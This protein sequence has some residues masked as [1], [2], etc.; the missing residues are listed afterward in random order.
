MAGSASDVFHF[1][2]AALDRFLLLLVVKSIRVRDTAVI[3]TSAAIGGS[4]TSYY[5]ITEPHMSP[6]NRIVLRLVMS[7]TCAC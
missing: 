1:V 3:M 6:D 2:L 4:V 5:S 7:E